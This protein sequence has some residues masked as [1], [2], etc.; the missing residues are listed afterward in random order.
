MK[1]I[2]KYVNFNVVVRF[3]GLIS[4]VIFQSSISLAEVPEF[5]NYQGRLTE[6]G[7]PVTGS[8][9]MTF[10]IYTVATGGT[11]IWDETRTITIN[12]GIFSVKLPIP[13]EKFNGVSTY[14]ETQVGTVILGRERLV[15]VPYAYHAAK[16]DNA[17]LSERATVADSLSGGLTISGDIDITGSI[18][19]KTREILRVDD[20]PGIT[21]LKN[22]GNHRVA[23][24][25]LRDVGVLEIVNEGV[26]PAIY[27]Y[28]NGDIRANHNVHSTNVI[29]DN[30]VQGYSM[31]ASNIVQ[32]D[33]LTARV[34]Q[35]PIKIGLS[36]DVFKNTS[37]IPIHT[38]ELVK[39]S[40]E[41]VLEYWGKD[42]IIPISGITISNVV[43]DTTIVGFVVGKAK[44]FKAGQE[45]KEGEDLNTIQPG[46][47]VMVVTLG[48]FAF[49]NVDTTNGPIKI[50]DLLTSSSNSGYAMK[51]K[52]PKIGTI[53]GKA[54][55]SLDSGAGK[56]A[57]LV[58][59][60]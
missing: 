17:T 48:S 36:T 26:A 16:S 55:Q 13:K 18:K 34:L 14:L 15:T 20:P 42:N 5:I 40:N 4:V 12:N 46:E 29:A 35:A 9:S 3:I 25:L 45:P 10:R 56:I 43:E 32:A 37:G 53:I 27:L 57:I 52:E 33:I 7:V 39:L 31:V 44:G 38:G 8:R 50:G 19:Y 1:K 60:R 59:V 6:S 47:Y 23:I 51:A 49:C 54:L 28:A 30:I 58:G 41:E 2:L 21:R 11:S 24:D 22:A